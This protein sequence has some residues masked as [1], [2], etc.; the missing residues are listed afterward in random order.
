[1]DR[2]RPLAETHRALASEALFDASIVHAGSHS[3]LPW[4]CAK[5]HEWEAVVKS[6]T[7]SGSGCPVCGN[8]VV[9]VGFN[10]LATTQPA[11]AAEAQF[12]PTTVTSGTSRKM[13]WRC[14][15]GHAW[16][17][18]VASRTRGAGC[19]VCSGRKV[20]SGHNDLATTHPRLAL[21]AL[22]DPTTVTA[23]ST[24]KLPWRCS[25]GHEW[26]TTPSHRSGQGQGC[27]YCANRR[28]LVGFNDLATT[29]PEVAAQARFDPTTVTFGSNKPMPWR[30][31]HGHEWIAPVAGRTTSGEGCPVCAGREVVA[32]LNDLATTHP[33]L[34][35]EA[36]F[37]ATT[38][39][40]GTHRRLP[41]RCEKGHEWVA[42]VKSRSSPEQA[43]GCPVCANKV[44]RPGV[45]DL[46]TTHP[47]LAAEALFDPT[48]VTHGSVR[49][50]R[51]RCR[52]GH[53]WT[54]T[55]GHR[56][57]RGQACPYCSNRR[58]LA[59]FND[60]MTTHSNLA[61]EALFDATKLTGGSHTK[62]P[63]RCSE[64]HEWTATPHSR[65]SGG[66]GCP[67]C[68]ATGF[69]PSKPGWLY[70]MRH[71]SW[72]LLQ[73]G[74]S[75]DIDTR[76]RTHRRRGWEPL[77]VRGPMAGHAARGWEV[78]ILEFLTGRGIELTPSTSTTVPARGASAGLGASGEAWWEVDYPVG[79]L[80]S[81]LNAVRDA[82]WQR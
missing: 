1:M 32:G 42:V 43:R 16:V 75:N 74:I 40:A 18:T 82:E 17:A 5:G 12:D 6:R 34:A 15:K 46:A 48:T 52:L 27:P 77:D 33:E 36:L 65:T 9:L 59:G 81:L 67:S 19:P 26:M 68:A 54:M 57:I 53:E 55:P 61:A 10:D 60:L 80:D 56:A 79:S 23:G 25:L 29:Y 28:V 51:W 49:R 50:L 47:E 64:G 69:D 58:V 76:L 31:R 2:K 37:D 4:R 14:A 13:P 20:W 3:K 22:F 39:S 30:C 21:E 11:L 35:A 7:A 63:W 41:W 62:L 66:S 73:V 8:K 38:V 24:L 78:A 72:A 71:Q 45:N 70:L 44:V